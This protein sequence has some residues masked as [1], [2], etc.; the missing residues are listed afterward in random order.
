[1]KVHEIKTDNIWTFGVLGEIVGTKEAVTL[2]TRH[3]TQQE[4]EWINNATDGWRQDI[5]IACYVRSWYRYNQH[6]SE[7]G[8]PCRWCKFV[9]DETTEHGWVWMTCND[10]AQSITSEDG[11]DWGNR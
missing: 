7:N 4:W 10:P 5:A 6:V 11:C 8:L 2:N 1:M 9:E 3:F